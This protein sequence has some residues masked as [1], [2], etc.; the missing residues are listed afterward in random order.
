MKTIKKSKTK[1]DGGLSERALLVSVNISQWTGR[2]I[3]KKATET[4]NI[5]H[6]ASASAG[7][8]HKKLL[9]GAAELEA[10]S[11]ITSQ[12]RKYFY[13]QTL[14]WFS[15]GS[16]ILSSK[17]Y[18]DFV[19]QMRKITSQFEGA[20]LDFAAA[21]PRLQSEAAKNLGDLYD[22]S[23]YP[24]DIKEK[25]KIEVNY[26]PLPS[27]KDFRTDISESEKQ[28]FIKKMQE[29][30]N[31][32]IKECW[33]KLHSVVNAAAVKLSQPDAIFR[34]S[35]LENITELVALLPKLNVNDDPGLEKSRKQ[36]E[37]LVS[38][39]D[40]GLLRSNSLERDKAS[41][42]L[43]DIESKMGAFMAGTVSK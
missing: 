38:S 4:A 7:N 16:R 19:E 14:P 18:L 36:V 39:L 32:A 34:D 1:K 8:Y 23:E 3:D 37:S 35:L 12:A 30:E 13:E 43:A 24:D 20:V 6:K 28:K 17:N 25:F 22:S 5:T 10:I 26:L 40:A 9:P 42:A 15:D 33:T 31:A 41:K 29:V 21:Y 11:T 27:V 2:R